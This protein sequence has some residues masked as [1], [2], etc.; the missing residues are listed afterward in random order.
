MWLVFLVETVSG[1]LSRVLDVTEGSWSV[2]L[3]KADSGS[4]TVKK[5]SLDGLGRNWFSPWQSSLLFVYDGPDGLVPWCGGP[6]TGW[7]SESQHELSFDW[8]GIRHIFE[9]RHLE[10]DLKLA[11]LSLGS[12]AWEVVKAGMDKPGG[13][14]PIVHGSP[15][16]QYSPGH[17]RTYEHWNLANNIVDKRLTELSEVINGPDMMFRPRWAN[18]DHTAVQWAFVHGTRVDPSIYQSW[19]PDWDTTVDSSDVEGFDMTSDAS[20]IATRVW[21]TGAGEGKAT[22]ITKAE[23]LSLVTEYFPFLESIISD[24]DQEKAEPIRQKCLGALSGAQ[25]MVDQLS[26]KVRADSEKNPLG[27]WFVGDDCRVT[28][29]DE[30]LSIPAGTRDMRILKASGNLTNSVSLELQEGQWYSPADL[31]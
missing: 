28:T 26:M 25:R 14:L 21:G 15:Y 7:P 22:V 27:S 17:Q 23:D 9:R 2:E 20:A 19:V 30:W 1:R 24:T 3:N 8:A 29:G 31:I 16:E 12:I 4:V 6:I 5:K 18:E 10:K 11:G 13:G